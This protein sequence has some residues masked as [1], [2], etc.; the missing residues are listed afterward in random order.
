MTEL[1]K[2]LLLIQTPYYQLVQRLINRIPILGE[3]LWCLSDEVGKNNFNDYLLN[4]L[5]VDE[6]KVIDSAFHTIADFK[7]NY[8]KHSWI[9][10]GETDYE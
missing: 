10:Y 5:N 9:C 3:D 6:V 1:L 7:W 8:N 2:Y 4:S